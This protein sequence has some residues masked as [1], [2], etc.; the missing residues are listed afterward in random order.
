LLLDKKNII[1]LPQLLKDFSE[2]L[3]GFRLFEKLK[4]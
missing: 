2:S 1:F 4:C 3:N